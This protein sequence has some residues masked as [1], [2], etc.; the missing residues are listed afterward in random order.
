MHLK[1]TGFHE[2]IYGAGRGCCLQLISSNTQR[3]RLP[4]ED[5]RFPQNITYIC[6]FFSR[7][8]GRTGDCVPRIWLLGLLSRAIWLQQHRVQPPRGCHGH[9]MGNRSQRNGVLVLQREGPLKFEEVSCAPFEF[10]AFDTRT[11]R[12]AHIYSLVVAEMCTASAL[13]SIGAVL[14]K[15]NPVQLTVAALLEVTG[16]VLNEWLLRSLLK[17]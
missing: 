1:K 3:T 2:G 15:T 5:L 8:P 6:F 10:A 16:F 4:S 9:P 7:V 11:W 14:G 17:V 12:N 13:I